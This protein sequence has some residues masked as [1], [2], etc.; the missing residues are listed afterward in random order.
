MEKD[1]KWGHKHTLLTLTS[2]GQI[3]TVI[4]TYKSPCSLS[5]RNSGWII[6][7]IAGVL[8]S[9]PVLTFKRFGKVEKG[10]SYIH[11]NKLVE[12]GIYSIVRHPQYLAGILISIG[13]Y[14]IAAGWLNMILGLAN[15]V[16]YNFGTFD[17]DE[18]LIAKF[19]QDYIDYRI[20]VPRLN[21]VLGLTRKITKALKPE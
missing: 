4:F 19:G 10:K 20:R 17:E 2:I 15:I 16:Q 6:L 18:R 14:M 11:T 3:L 9:I 1:F 13:L 8:G 5:L 21:I 7:W 12:K